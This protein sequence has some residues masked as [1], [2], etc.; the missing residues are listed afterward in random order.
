M[1]QPLGLP[2]DR[3]QF[4]SFV[5]L[6]LIIVGVFFRES[7]GRFVA[8]VIAS[9]PPVLKRTDEAV[10]WTAKLCDSF[11]FIYKLSKMMLLN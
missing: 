4:C 11:R 1:P 8:T 7:I 10:T 9:S 2:E 3:G 6:L 5:G